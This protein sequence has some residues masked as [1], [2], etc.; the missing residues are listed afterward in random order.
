MNKMKI[1]CDFHHSGLYAS[2]HYL[3]ENRLGHQLYRPIG[4]E[5]F[6]KGYWKIAEPYNNN[7]GT[8]EQYLGIREGY[9][10]PDGTQPLNDVS[11]IENGVYYIKD[12][13][14]NITHKA[15][16]LE[17]FLSMDFDIIIASIPAHIDAYTKLIKDY[18]LRTKLVY[19]I[20]NIGWHSLI[21]FNKV[22][23]I[24][25]SVKPFSVPDSN[26]VVF[27][28]QEFDLGVFK[29]AYTL[30]KN[31]FSF[32]NCLPQPLKW[33]EFKLLLPEYSFKSYGASCPDGTLGTTK[34]IAK[35]MQRAKFGYHNKPHGDGFGHVIHNWLAVGKP[36]LVNLDDYRDK[37]VG[38]LLNEDT[39]IDISRGVRY[40]ADCI[41][42]ITDLQ[43][44]DMCKSVT[45]TFKEVNF[46]QDAAKVRVFLNDL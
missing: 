45:V 19:Q 18:G 10:P 36:L 39:C 23:N 46:E 44:A 6:E 1:F 17:K 30:E 35:E 27:Y 25:A 42:E 26:N 38:E 4:K 13:S 16:T 11:D 32:V 5:W 2:L 14:N 29:P 9:L 15:V 37:L 34:L 12:Y 41:K 40:V 43:Y 7:P 8:I 3:L 24:M 33:E 21:P 22:R 28:R 20:G 31:I